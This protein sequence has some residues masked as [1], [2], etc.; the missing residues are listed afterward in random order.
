MY[1]KIE[2]LL[3]IPYLISQLDCL[4]LFTSKDF[5]L[6]KIIFRLITN[7]VNG[8]G[9]YLSS[10][11]NLDNRNLFQCIEELYNVCNNTLY[12]DND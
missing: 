11:L 4:T 10:I 3:L 7:F 6:H 1:C 5:N 12:I 8:K 9:I 2:Q